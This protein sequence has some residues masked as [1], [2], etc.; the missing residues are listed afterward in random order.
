M[1]I[2]NEMILANDILNEIIKRQAHEVA[3]ELAKAATLFPSFHIFDEIPACI[4][5][6]I[7]NEMI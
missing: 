3:H 1:S 5:D 4:F 7:F 2:S 6:L